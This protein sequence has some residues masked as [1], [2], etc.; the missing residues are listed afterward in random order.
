VNEGG[1]V[2]PRPEGARGKAIMSAISKRSAITVRFKLVILMRF[3][4]LKPFADA[5]HPRTLDAAEDER[6]SHA[7][8]CDL[9]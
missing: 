6:I 8:R 4:A 7:S 2:S 5:Q 1:V 9:L 3:C